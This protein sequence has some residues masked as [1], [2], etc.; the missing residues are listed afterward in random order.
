MA[1]AVEDERRPIVCR[2]SWPVR[3]RWIV[4]VAGAGEC[5]PGGG[6]PARQIV[7]DFAAIRRSD[8]I[9]G[10]EHERHVEGMESL[11]PAAKHRRLPIEGIEPYRRPALRCLALGQRDRTQAMVRIR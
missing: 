6:D 11:E 4:R 1:V 3:D 10:L 9:Y 7:G 2:V 5:R 8:R